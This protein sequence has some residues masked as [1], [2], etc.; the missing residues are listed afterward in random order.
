VTK[1]ELNLALDRIALAATGLTPPGCPLV[2]LLGGPR[3]D[4]GTR[5]LAIAHNL[6]A[7]P[8]L[9]IANQVAGLLEDVAKQLRAGKGL[10]PGCAGHG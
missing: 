5:A 1:P 3:R 7:G 2:M 8:G 10:P 9:P 4:T 6:E